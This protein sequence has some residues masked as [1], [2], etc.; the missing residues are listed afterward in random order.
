V[1]TAANPADIFTKSLPVPI[2]RHHLDNIRA[3]TVFGLPSL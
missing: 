2:L 1:R 3:G